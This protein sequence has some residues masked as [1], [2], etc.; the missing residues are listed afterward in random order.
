[1]KLSDYISLTL[2]EIAEG[3]RKATKN[4]KEKGDGCVLSETQMKIDGIPFA[5]LYGTNGGD[6]YKPIIKVAFRVG[7]EVEESK[8]SNHKLGG[9]LK[10][11]STSFES[12]S[13]DGRRNTHEVSFELPLILPIE[14]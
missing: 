12:L 1:M 11:I 7:V 14:K 3:V 4:Y 9:S 10:V 5:R 8:E 13:G 6:T 2:T